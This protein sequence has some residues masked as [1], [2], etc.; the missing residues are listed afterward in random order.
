MRAFL[1]DLDGTLTDPREGITRSIAYALERLGVE[2]PPADDLLFAIG[3]P[4]RASLAQLLGSA[5][6]ETVEKALAHF[7]ERFADVGLFENRPYD[8]IVEALVAISGSGR[9]LVVATSKPRLYA[10]RIVDHFALGAHF[11]HVHGSELDGT[12]ADKRELIGY[13]LDHHGIRAGDAVMIGDRGMDMSAA[14]HHGVTAMG[15]LWGYGSREELEAQGAQHL[16]ATPRELAAA[17]ARVDAP[18]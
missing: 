13:I 8:G 14:R 17:L 15:A 4:L 12:R 7:R 11:S 6:P 3:P 10:R 9:L 1:F 5:A 2:P 16:C 18:G